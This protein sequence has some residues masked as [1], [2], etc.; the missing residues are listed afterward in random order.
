MVF[1]FK[2]YLKESKSPFYNE[3]LCPLFWEKEGD[4]KELEWKLDPLVSKKLL[5]IANDF[6][7]E[8]S[9]VLKKKDVLDIQLVGSL[10]GYNWNQYSDLD[11]HIIVNFKDMGDDPK[12]IDYAMYGLK[13]SWNTKHDITMR[14]H[15]VEIAVQDE[16][17][18]SY[19]STVYSLTKKK[20]I[21]KPKYSPPKIDEFMVNKKFNSLAY[22]ISKLENKLVLGNVFPSNPK[23]LYNMAAKLKSRIMKMRKE[24]LSKGGEF[25]AGNLV[26][27]KLRSEGY[28][29]KLIDTITKSYDKIYT[30]K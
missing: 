6:I 26:F 23:P 12:M 9:D 18:E 10:T 30:I 5:D 3:E 17:S 24:S 13:F 20:W 29:G 22:D 7:E 4:G 25:S 14:G 19:I 21:K 28:I 11:L 15:D 27:K 16:G 8:G 1:N 2:S